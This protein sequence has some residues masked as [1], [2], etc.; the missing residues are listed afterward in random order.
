MIKI[1]NLN[2]FYN[3]NKNNEIHVIDNTNLEITEPGLVTFLGQSGA[4][5]TTLLHV[6]GGLD[7]AKGDIIYEDVNFLK[8]SQNKVDEYRNK[9]I[10]Y[11]F[12][13]YNL[14][15][16]LTVYEN[17]KVQ[18][19]LIGVYDKTI[20]D[21]RIN[22]AL[23]IV[24]LERYKRRNVTALSGG[25]QQRVAIARALV[26]GCKIIIADEPTGN[27]D[28]RNSIEIM[29]ILKVLSKKYYIL[30]VTHDINLATHY[31][32]RII[33]ISDGKIIEDI[34]NL[35][36]N[37]LLNLDSN[38]L[39]LKEYGNKSLNDAGNKVEVYSKND[40]SINFRVIIEKD[41][42][43]IENNNNLPIRVLNE[44]TD[45]YIVDSTFDS[46]ELDESVTQFLLNNNLTEYNKKD[47][48]R[49][50]IKNGLKDFK[51]SLYNIFNSSLKRKF[52]FIAFFIIGIILC[53][54]LNALNISTTVSNSMLEG[55]PKNSVKVDFVNSANN[56][57]FGYSFEK[58]ELV[59]IFNE[60]PEITGVAEP[61]K[62][63]FMNFNVISNRPTKIKFNNTCFV[64]TA[65]IYIKDNIKLE[66]NEIAIS[67]HIADEI[68]EYTS[69][70]NI[71][72]YDDLKGQTLY[73]YLPS[74]YSGDVIIKE[75]IETYDYTFLVSDFIYYAKNK[76]SINMSAKMLNYSYY[77][78]ISD[79]QNIIPIQ[80]YIK[81]KGTYADY[82]KPR[83][84]ISESLLRF[85]IGI[86]HFTSTDKI[87]NWITYSDNFSIVGYVENDG[88]DVIF[89]SEK[90]YNDFLELVAL[91][92]KSIVA[93]TNYELVLSEGSE[94]PINN[95]EII[96]P[97]TSNNLRN[98]PIGSTYYV[99]SDINT[100][101]A[102][103]VT[104]YFEIEYPYNTSFIFTND[105]TAYI[106]GSLS[107]HERIYES[108]VK[109]L[110]FY[111]NDIEKTTQYFKDYGYSAGDAELIAMNN[112]LFAKINSSKVIIAISLCIIVA[113]I[114]FVF[115]INR[116]KLMQ[117]IYK[118]GV[119]RALG[120]KK[121]VLYKDFIIESIIITTLTIALGFTLTYFIT[122]KANTFIPGIAVDITY[123]YISM[124]AIYVLMFISSI[125]PV[126]FLLRKTPV[127]I[128][129]KYDI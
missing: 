55:T 31:S 88:F 99:Q 2:K 7:K 115:F 95:Y 118:I 47:N 73:L 126:F 11:I 39:Y 124:I 57:K 89:T 116:S 6:I 25:Q 94:Y 66:D 8:S 60:A 63:A 54:C 101:I 52:I 62:G 125:S 28:T 36:N 84:I 98:Y 87:F 97:K 102:L 22:D 110:Y 58:N 71:C 45:K 104:G 123:Y 33:K 13:H 53:F 10:G 40:Q 75:V 61:V 122:Y 79:V 30:L 90:E 14:L 65:N 24:G 111:T 5:K 105:R 77:E 56:S 74:V 51:Y 42:I 127:E 129:S 103:Q 34:N 1:K 119:L 23:K 50:K 112:S 38:A 128:I 78:K 21:N 64:S 16:N 49:S 114:L 85:F 93:Y 92:S 72:S 20:I 82:D 96:L 18:L 117:D 109:T 29:N 107:A 17:L 70:Y 12:Q 26:K 91:D 4:G 46:K 19:D 100:K 113:M 106:I 48:L 86:D 3:K 44:N 80:D 43:Y 27:L 9:N 15:P 76:S 35:N 59:T 32:D 68:L 81:G 83:A 108:D 37:S 41:A 121:F 69:K 120:A 67:N